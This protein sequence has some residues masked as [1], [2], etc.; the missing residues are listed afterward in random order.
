MVVLGGATSRTLVTVEPPPQEPAP[1]LGGHGELV[2]QPIKTGVGLAREQIG[3]GQPRAHATFHLVV[4]S[5]VAFVGHDPA[6]VLIS[7]MAAEPALG[8][9]VSASM[10]ARIVCS[11]R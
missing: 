2:E 3:I 1:G 6:P 11:A 10:E 5:Q 9:R 7:F 4:W 8:G